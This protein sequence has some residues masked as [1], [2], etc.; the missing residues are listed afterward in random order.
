MPL[1]PYRDRSPVGRLTRP[2]AVRLGPVAR[3]SIALDRLDQRRFWLFVVTAS[4]LA[5]A[6]WSI[7]ASRSVV[8]GYGTFRAVAIADHDLSPGQR[9]TSDDLRWERWPSSV[10]VHYP[11]AEHLDGAVLRSSVVA[12]EPV[13]RSDLF[14]DPVALEP[15]ER[16][17]TLPLPIA[18]PPVGPGDIVELI[19]LAPGF[20]LGDRQIIDTRALGQGRVMGIDDTGLTVAVETSQVYAIVET[21]AVGSV[22]IVLTAFRS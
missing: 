18:P 12:G 1:P 16:A 19:G 10:A 4:I 21:M 2:D 5:L 22:E 20:Q 7:G 15:E 8:A 14:D 3:V 6:Y 9:L 13:A 17:I 11:V